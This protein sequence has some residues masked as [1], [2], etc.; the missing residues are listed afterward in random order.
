[1][2]LTNCSSFCWV[3]AGWCCGHV[4]F[5]CRHFASSHRRDQMVIFGDSFLVAALHVIEQLEA[6]A[7]VPFRD[8]IALPIFYAAIYC[9]SLLAKLYW[10]LTTINVL[11]HRDG[12]STCRTVWIQDVVQSKLP[13]VPVV[14]S[15]M[16]PLSLPH[17]HYHPWVHGES[18][19]I[20]CTASSRL[21]LA[22]G[23]G[24]IPKAADLRQRWLMRVKG[25]R[26]HKRKVII[27]EVSCVQE[28]IWNE[29]QDT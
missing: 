18:S 27:L 26:L 16:F 29:I 24:C 28:V 21:Q 3:P 15:H 7:T 13:L 8:T 17:F 25:C 9:T 22:L 12:L 11:S 2:S 14:V 19:P 5:Q 6:T 1:M 10:D 4:L 23:A 20:G